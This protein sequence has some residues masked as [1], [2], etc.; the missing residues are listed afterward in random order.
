MPVFKCQK[1]QFERP[2]LTTESKILANQRLT[3]IE[4]CQEYDFHQTNSH[5]PISLPQCFN[6]WT[7]SRKKAMTQVFAQL[8]KDDQNLTFPSLFT[9]CLNV[10]IWQS[11][12]VLFTS[13]QSTVK[14][15]FRKEMVNIRCWRR[16]LSDA[17]W[18][19]CSLGPCS[20]SII[21]FPSGSEAVRCGHLHFHDS[22]FSG[23]LCSPTLIGC[24]YLTNFHHI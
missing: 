18:P 17:R 14:A 8:P 21:Y 13:E 23:V 16:P 2:N 12:F 1:W 24:L 20:L 15:G 9:I 7:S 22:I 5:T 10:T 19:R 4:T 6:Y 11:S 3:Y